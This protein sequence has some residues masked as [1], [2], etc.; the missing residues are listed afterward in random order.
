MPTSQPSASRCAA[1]RYRTRA[2][3]ERMPRHVSASPARPVQRS[4]EG[5]R[6]R[7]EI[8]I[9]RAQ[10]VTPES[11]GERTE[12]TALAPSLSAQNLQVIGAAV[13]E[14]HELAGEDG[15]SRPLI[16]RKPSKGVAAEAE[17]TERKVVHAV[18]PPTPSI[19]TANAA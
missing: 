14:A 11:R 13:S 10:A 6:T 19:L 16:V 4:A 9:S 8:F 17:G 7:S 1:Q 18:H 15:R 12:A 2:E 3:A 5:L